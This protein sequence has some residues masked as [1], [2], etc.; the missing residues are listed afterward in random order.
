MINNYKFISGMQTGTDIAGVKFAKNNGFEYTG[1]MPKGFRTEKG[2]KPQYKEL[3]NAVE[4]KSSNYLVRTEKNVIASD[5]TLIF[6]FA[7]SSGSKKTR[8]IC[9]KRNIPFAYFRSDNSDVIV[10]KLKK[11]FEEN[12]FKTINIAGNRESRSPGIEKKVYNILEQVFKKT[13]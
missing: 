12:N 6:D 7:V 2:N 11:F 5:V 1:F 9:M 8:N 3:Y 13:E 10:N 4:T